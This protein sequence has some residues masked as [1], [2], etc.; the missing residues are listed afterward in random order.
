[1]LFFAPIWPLD[2]LYEEYLLARRQNGRIIRAARNY[3]RRNTTKKP[4][5][6]SSIFPT[7]RNT[8]KPEYE[9]FFTDGRIIRAA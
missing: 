2:L 8:K 5:F 4:E 1:M 9:L 6:E 3:E 7:R